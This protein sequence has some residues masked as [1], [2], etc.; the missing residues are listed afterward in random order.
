MTTT[1]QNGFIER[2]IC[3]LCG[4]GRRRSLIN[5][6]Y[7][8]RALKDYLDS[9]YKNRLPRE[10]VINETFELVRCQDCGFVWQHYVPNEEQMAILYEHIISAEESL[11]KKKCSPFSFFSEYASEMFIIASLCKGNPCQ[12]NVL[13]FG[14][15]W[16]Y[17]SLMAKGFGFKT[18]GFEVSKTRME[19]AQHNGITIIT[20]E[21]IPGS[22]FDF[23]NA[24]QVFEHIQ[25][26]L[27]T[28]RYL[29]QGLRKDGIIRI[30]VPN[31][32]KIR[33]SLTSETLSPILPIIH[34]LEHINCFSPASLENLG[35]QAGLRVLPGVGPGF[36]SK[37]IKIGKILLPNN[38]I[39]KRGST[40]YFQKVF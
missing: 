14:M 23:V 15:G 21:S 19:Y 13:D 39:F 18:S 17:W 12:I 37:L 24:E 1:S 6:P 2:T 33:R 11:E 28:L 27:E 10:F 3:E 7:S 26:P 40:L 30:A 31:G 16:G 22:N 5:L 9:F 29:L 8:H 34:P 25:K 36:K 4:S 20:W 32:R 35:R 38:R